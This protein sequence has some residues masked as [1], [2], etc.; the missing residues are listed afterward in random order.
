MMKNELDNGFITIRT[1]ISICDK[2]GRSFIAKR[3]LMSICDK[4][5]LHNAILLI[6]FIATFPE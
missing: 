2:N 4:N 6:C 1:L 3:N 5:G